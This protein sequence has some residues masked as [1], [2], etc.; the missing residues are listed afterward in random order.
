MIS[1][2]G[3]AFVLR[4]VF[5]LKDF[6]KTFLAFL[7]SENSEG[8]FHPESGSV[9]SP[10]NTSTGCLTLDFPV[11]GT[12]RNECLLFT[13]CLLNGILLHLPQMTSTASQLV[14]S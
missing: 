10:N 8:R 3:R 6:R 13:H 9:L 11:S 12:V 4:L 14:L 7:Q 2:Q 1:C 5:F